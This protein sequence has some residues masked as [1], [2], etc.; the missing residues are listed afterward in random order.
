ML[1]VRTALTQVFRWASVP[2]T[3]A[4]CQPWSPRCAGAG[5]SAFAGVADSHQG[6]RFTND[7]IRNWLQCGCC[8]G[9]ETI[10]LLRRWCCGLPH[11]IAQKLLDTA[12]WRYYSGVIAAQSTNRFYRIV[13]RI[14]R[15]FAGKRLCRLS[16]V[17]RH[18]HRRILLLLTVVDRL[19]D[20]ANLLPV[21]RLMNLRW[22][23]VFTV[24]RTLPGAV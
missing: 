18:L 8:T 17:C 2:L 21:G 1:P 4:G 20:P 10:W 9:G 23:L 19:R 13:A 24:H 16:L 5:G 12:R 7:G 3:S 11:Q 15:S 6:P 22:R 14:S